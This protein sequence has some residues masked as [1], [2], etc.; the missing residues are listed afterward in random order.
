MQTYI[1]VLQRRPYTGL[2]VGCVPGPGC[3]QP[4]RPLGRLDRNLKEVIA[5]L[6]EAVAG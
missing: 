5:M 3:A 2:Y 1:A 4:G 6:L